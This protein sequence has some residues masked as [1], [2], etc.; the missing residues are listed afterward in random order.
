[1]KSQFWEKLNLNFKANLVVETQVFLS[2]K[3]YKRQVFFSLQISSLA[4]NKQ[5]L[6][7]PGLIQILQFQKFFLVA[8]AIYFTPDQLKWITQ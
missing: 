5:S 4:L 8:C 6:F 7:H 3:Q 2:S 1:M